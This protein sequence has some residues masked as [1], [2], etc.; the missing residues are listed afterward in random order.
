[1]EP[2]GSAVVLSAGVQAK[3]MNHRAG[4]TERRRYLRIAPK[5][6]FMFR[7]NAYEQRGRIANLCEGG[8]F[9]KTPLTTPARLLARPVEIELRFDAGHGDWLR[10]TGRVSRIHGD[11][12]AVMFDTLAP[13]LLRSIDD[14]TSA[15]RAR[16]RVISVVLVDADTDRRAAMVAGFR[17]T[18]CIVVDAATPLEAIVRLGESSFEPDVIAIADS[19]PDEA[20][21]QM[22]AFVEQDHPGAKLITIGDEVLKPDGFAIWLSSRD[23]NA[24][25]SA[26]VREALVTP[27]RGR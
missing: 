20:A 27:R 6:A 15:S 16:S 24:D 23:P 2:H 19:H 26:R 9:V 10:A 22:R 1:L 3:T 12:A 13:Q 25:L 17:A 18:G 11:G 21:E 4:A 8:A 5:G 7:A 14:L